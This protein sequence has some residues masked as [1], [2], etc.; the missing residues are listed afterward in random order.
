M[1][2][3]ATPRPP[4]RRLSSF[5]SVK[6]MRVPEAPSGW[7]KA[8]APPLT[9]NFS[10]SRSSS[11][12]TARIWPAKASLISKRSTSPKPIPARSRALRIAGAGP[13]PMRDG[14]T[15][16]TAQ[17]T[18]LPSGFQP[19]SAARAAVE[20]IIIA[21]PSTMPEALPAVTK[22]SLSKAVG[23][24]A[25]SSIVLSGRMWSSRSTSLA[26]LPFPTGTATTSCDSRQAFHAS[27]ARRWERMA[28]RSC[29]S[30]LIP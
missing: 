28:K 13:I 15:P 24:V 5:K 11:L 21:A 27:S 16:T 3:E 26:R 18:I 1:Q 10:T 4:P 30:R 20:R 14:S 19:R 22:P 25:S 9:F 7:P 8:M 29:S 17:E 23:S 2:A 12:T 6:R